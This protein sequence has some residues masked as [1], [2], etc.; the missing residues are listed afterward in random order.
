[1]YKIV[2][3]HNRELSVFSKYTNFHYFK[4]W[5]VVSVTNIWC[6]LCYQYFP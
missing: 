6:G 2:W 5:F 4:I 1:M 3:Y